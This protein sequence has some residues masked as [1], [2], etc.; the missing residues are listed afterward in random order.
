MYYKIKRYFDGLEPPTI[1]TKDLHATNVATLL[2]VAEN[3]G[4]PNS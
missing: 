3:Y 1:E 4:V 2:I